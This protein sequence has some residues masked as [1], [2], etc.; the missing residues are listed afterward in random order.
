MVAQRLTKAELQAH[1]NNNKNIAIGRGGGNHRASKQ[2]GIG[3]HAPFYLYLDCVQLTQHLYQ[4]KKKGEKFHVALCLVV[5]LKTRGFSFWQY[6][7]EGY[8]EME[9]SNDLSNGPLETKVCSSYRSLSKTSK[10][11]VSGLHIHRLR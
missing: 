3:K 7:E 11:V 2:R 10:M 6:I 8:E 1:P 4:Q 5:F 9:C